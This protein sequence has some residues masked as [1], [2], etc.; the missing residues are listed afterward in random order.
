[1]ICCDIQKTFQS[2]FSIN[3]ILCTRRTVAQR[4]CCQAVLPVGF[5]KKL[6]NVYKK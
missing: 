1:M 6:P 2:Y 3:K 5:S 4:G